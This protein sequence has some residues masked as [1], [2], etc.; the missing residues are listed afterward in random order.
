LVIDSGE[1]KKE[2]CLKIGAEKWLDFQESSDLIGD[3]KAA[4]DGMGPHAAIITAPAVSLIQNPKV[5]LALNTT[6]IVN[7]I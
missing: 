2:L 6:L 3:V 7:A 5:C 4:T 1:E